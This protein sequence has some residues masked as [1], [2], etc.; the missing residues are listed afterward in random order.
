MNK[1]IPNTITVTVTDS[2]RDDKIEITL[3]RYS[4][5]NDWIKVFKTILIHQTFCEDTVKELF[6]YPCEEYNKT[7]ED[8][9]EYSSSFNTPP[10]GSWWNEPIGTAVGKE[11][12]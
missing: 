8:E 2:S 12:W 1:T 3:N 4:D 6:E 9:I 5:L 10:S 7:M 11:A